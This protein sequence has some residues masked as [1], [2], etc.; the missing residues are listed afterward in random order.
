MGDRLRAAGNLTAIG[1][2]AALGSAGPATP[3]LAS[4]SNLPGP[5]AT[6]QARLGGLGY[7]PGPVDGVMSAKTQ[8]AMRAYRR[9]A[10]R[11]IALGPAGDPIA[12][13]QTALRR[14][15]FLSVPADGA[16]GPQTRNAIIRF[17][18]ASHSPIDPRVSDGLLAA[19][20]RAEAPPV[21]PNAGP[22]PAS[23]APPAEPEVTGRQ[24]LPPGMT[25][26]PIR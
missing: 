22:P 24:P 21:V 15:G 25:P 9:A 14:L 18:V 13:A 1:L 23:T 19:L 2:A 11:P 20:A 17:Q 5:I 8:Q 3:G 10:G 7:A 6:L 26:P 4:A 12:V 16:I